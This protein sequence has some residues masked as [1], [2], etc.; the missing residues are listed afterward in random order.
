M[1][2]A[3]L[4]DRA[5]L[6]AGAAAMSAQGIPQICQQ[7]MWRHESPPIYALGCEHHGASWL[8]A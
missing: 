8:I 6:L 1:G 4:G 5:T 7:Q 2:V 3:R